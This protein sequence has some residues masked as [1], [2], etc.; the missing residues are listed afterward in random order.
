MAAVVPC[1]LAVVLWCVPSLSLWTRLFTE[2]AHP[3]INLSGLMSVWLQTE[4][5]FR[6]RSERAAGAEAAEQTDGGPRRETPNHSFDSS[7]P[8]TSTSDGNPPAPVSRVY[9]HE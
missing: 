9:T 2:S 5:S 3:V 1:L 4:G 6:A 8:T 7:S